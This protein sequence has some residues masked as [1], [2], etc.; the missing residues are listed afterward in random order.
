MLRCA[1]VDA[2]LNGRALVLSEALFSEEVAG[3]VHIQFALRDAPSAK[4]AVAL[5]LLRAHC[6]ARAILFESCEPLAGVFRAARRA[7]RNNREREDGR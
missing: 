3:V 2:L 1:F 6:F 5:I 7:E 4:V